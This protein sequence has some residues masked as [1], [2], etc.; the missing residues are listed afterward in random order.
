MVI[1]RVGLV[2]GALAFLYVAWASWSA[3]YPPEVASVR[4]IVAFI[5]VV[6][7]GYVGELIVAT[8]PVVMPQAAQDADAASEAA[9]APAVA[10]VD[11]EAAATPVA[12]AAAAVAP[13]A[14]GDPALAAGQ[15]LPSL[16]A[17]TPIV[18]PDVAANPAATVEAEPAQLRSAA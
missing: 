4:G 9:A 12:D 5:A 16:P 11:F 15:Q 2:V 10:A 14:A 3:G 13:V 1:L 18:A 7:V 8:A 17:G 6:I